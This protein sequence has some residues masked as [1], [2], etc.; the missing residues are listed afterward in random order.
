[1]RK[2]ICSFLFAFLAAFVAL[3]GTARAAAPTTSSTQTSS[4]NTEAASSS[5]WQIRPAVGLA[6]SRLGMTFKHEK[7]E[8]EYN[9]TNTNF[10]FL[11]IGIGSLSAQLKVPV[12]ESSE[13][14]AEYGDTR[15][16]DYQIGFGFGKQWRAEAYYQH[17]Q[18]YYLETDKKFASGVTEK[19]LSEVKPN[20]SSKR[21]GGQLSYALSPAYDQGLTT[22][23]SWEQDRDAGSLI[24]ATGFDR[25][26]M[27]GDIFPK[28]VVKAGSA[29]MTR[30]NVDALSVR[31]GYGYNWISAQGYF[32]VMGSF[33]GSWNQV[34]STTE[35]SAA[36]DRQS[37]LDMTSS[38][39]GAAGL[40][41]GTSKL[42]LFARA[43]LWSVNLNKEDN[44]SSTTA[45]SGLFYATTF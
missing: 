1:M 35:G 43:L 31:V 11:D 45:L 23:T 7:T 9:S 37:Q 8:W 16:Q 34:E 44:L 6:A 19:S 39:A 27:D 17:Y 29:P 38:L 28:A 18:G 21:W 20:L 36:G 41:W 12:R 14:H 24:V 32:G 10:I 4:L 42:G 5:T 40:R 3:S 30:F 15:V 2:A 26:S 25:F 33:G 22:G 13:R